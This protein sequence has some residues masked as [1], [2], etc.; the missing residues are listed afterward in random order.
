MD[1]KTEIPF[2]KLE[3]IEKSGSELKIISPAYAGDESE[4]TSILQYVYQSIVLKKDGFTSEGKILE[5]IALDEMR[6]F[7]LLGSMIYRLGEYPVFTYLPPHPINYFSTR[8]VTYSKTLKK[9]IMDDMIAEQYAIDGYSKMLYK[10][11]D[12]NVSAVIQRIRMDELRHLHMLKE[13]AN[14]LE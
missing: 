10:L 14:D 11:K 13:I 12:E 1:E 8:S 9:M 3:G 2:P 6:H 7:E 4:L 5:G